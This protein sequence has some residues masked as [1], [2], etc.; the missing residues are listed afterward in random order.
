MKYKVKRLIGKSGNAYYV[1][2]YHGH[3]EGSNYD[4][5]IAKCDEEIYAQRIANA[6]NQME[7]ES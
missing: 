5:V 6:L 7:I 1:V 2:F 3:F 4:R